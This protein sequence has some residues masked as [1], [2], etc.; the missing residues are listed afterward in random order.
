MSALPLM[1]SSRTNDQIDRRRAK[2][3]GVVVL[4]VSADFLAS[5]FTI[6]NEL[7]RLLSAAEETGTAILTLILSACRFE[8]TAG[9]GYIILY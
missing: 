3:H 6:T 5:G 8:K 2:N 7:P 9:L 4:L 1:N